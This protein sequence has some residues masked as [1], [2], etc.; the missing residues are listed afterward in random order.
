MDKNEMSS[1]E[2]EYSVTELDIE[3]IDGEFDPELLATKA[4]LGANI[5]LSYYKLED[6]ALPFS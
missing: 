3:D 5:S 2:L 4:E 1:D 6:L